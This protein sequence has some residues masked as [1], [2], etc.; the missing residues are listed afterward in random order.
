[1]ASSHT[2]HKH[3]KED[4]KSFSF[5][6]IIFDTDDDK[7]PSVDLKIFDTKDFNASDLMIVTT[8]LKM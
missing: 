5:D 7:Y 8:T 2:P 4:D 3:E 6:L 1:M